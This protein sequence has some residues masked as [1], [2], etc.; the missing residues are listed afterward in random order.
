MKASKTPIV[1]RRFFEVEQPMKFIAMDVFSSGD[2]KTNVLVVIDRALRYTVLIKLKNLKAQTIVKEFDERIVR[3]F[4]P[5]AKVLTDGGSCFKGDFE[6]Y[7]GTLNIEHKVG[8][9][10]HHETNGI[11]ERAIRTTRKVLKAMTVKNI[12]DWLTPTQLA[13][14]TVHTPSLDTLLLSVCLVWRQIQD[15]RIC[16][17]RIMMRT[18]IGRENLEC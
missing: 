18:Q 14:N 6:K 7:L 17:M 10:Y 8:K 4:G 12:E 5:P 1:K 13:L 11:T 9:P 16:L 3:M 15:S 2:E